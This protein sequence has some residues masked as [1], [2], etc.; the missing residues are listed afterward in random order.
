MRV[1]R[2]QSE[3]LMLPQAIKSKYTHIKMAKC[4]SGLPYDTTHKN[5]NQIYYV[6]VRGSRVK[7]KIKINDK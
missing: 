5:L 7:S 3:S 6:P 2:V 4:G 1:L